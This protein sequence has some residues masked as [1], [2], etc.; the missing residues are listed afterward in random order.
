MSS[1]SLPGGLPPRF[2]LPYAWFFLFLT[3]GRAHTDALLAT[4]SGSHRQSQ[5]CRRR[6]YCLSE[7]R[8]KKRRRLSIA[9]CAVWFRLISLRL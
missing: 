8:S 4:G 1:A 5:P 9:G 7:K 2:L 3:Y 6:L